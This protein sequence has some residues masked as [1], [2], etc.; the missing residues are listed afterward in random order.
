MPKPRFTSTLAHRIGRHGAQGLSIALRELSDRG[1]IDVRGLPENAEFMSA[2][3]KVI[4]FDLP[5][6]PRTA[7]EGDNLAALW[8]SVDQWLI[9]LPRE[10]IPALATS[11]KEALTGIYSLCVDLSDARTIFRLEGDGVR[12]VLNKGTSVDFTNP[13]IGKGTVRRLRYAEIAAMVHVAGTNPDVMDLYVFRSYADYAWEY[14]V[15]SA[16]DSTRLKLFGRQ[17]APLT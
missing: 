11:L 8:L 12:E 16:K 17:E 9:T 14:L 4:G 6:T 1:M 7:M 2:M 15:T 3:K 13:E 10:K 5:M